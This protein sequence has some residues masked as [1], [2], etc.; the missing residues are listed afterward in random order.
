M[1][2]PEQLAH[3]AAPPVAA[4]EVSARLIELIRTEIRRNGGWIGF[5]R[6]MKLALYAPGLGY[7][8]GGAR[9]LGAAGDFVTAP[10][11]SAL[12][13]RTL[14]RQIAQLIG[15]GFDHVLEFGAGSGALAADLLLELDAL[16]AAPQR[17]SI[18]EPSPDLRERARATIE[19]RAAGTLPRVEWL[20]ALPRR[21]TGIV[22]ANEVLDAMPAHAV[23]V[24]S[25]RIEELGV[26]E[27]AGANPFAWSA[28]P[29]GRELAEAAAALRLPE[30]YCTE[31]SLAARGWMRSLGDLLERGAILIADYGFP[32]HEYYHPQRAGGTLMCHYRH[33]AHPDPLCLVGLQDISVHVDFSALAD[34]ACAS[35]LDLLGYATQAQFLINCGI[36][37]LLAQTPAEDSATYLPLAAQAQ[38]LLSPAE[39]GELFKVIAFGKG[40][41]QALI[42]FTR[43]DR[44]HTL[45]P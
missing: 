6:Y 17:Y 3:L 4:R 43:G 7:Y 5:A 19:R 44:S 18:L 45:R 11:S 38:R 24:R 13:G 22:V 27:S 33:H 30:G 31:I 21:F 14:A 37:A 40:I 23:H 16:G 28:R 32:A 39:M 42:G 36:T 8:S 41:G 15:A 29:A 9:K 2:I 1:N 35:G 26:V 20:Q 10:E 34:A 12:F 25:G